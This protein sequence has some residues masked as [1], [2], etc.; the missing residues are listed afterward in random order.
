[1]SGK[2][3]F[4]RSQGIVPFGVGSI[5]NFPDDSLMMAGLDMWPTEI[6]D[7]TLGKQ[8]QFA[9]QIID[10]RLQRRLSFGREVKIDRFLS[11][12]EAP[13]MTQGYYG[14]SPLQLSTTGLMPFVRFPE[15][16]YCPACRTLH[17][18]PWN[19]KTGDERL[20]CNSK[21]SRKEGASKTC[22]DLPER[23]KHSLIPVRFAVACKSGH[24]MD[25]PWKE[26]VHKNNTSCGAG[27][28]ELFFYP[29]PTGGMDGLVIEC[30]RCKKRNTL[31]GIFGSNPFE[32]IWPT[33]PGERPWL[34]PKAK[35]NGC[36]CPP[37]SIQR[38]ASNI[39]FS[40][41]KS[42]ILIPPYSE[43][44]N[45]ILD[46]PD[47]WDLIQSLTKVNG[48]IADKAPLLSLAKKHGIESKLF[49]Q[50][51]HEKLDSVNEGE[52][53]ESE[54]QYRFT[55]YNAFLGPRPPFEE[56][57][58]FDILNIPIER[59]GSDF[60]KYISTVVLVKN[61]RE[62]RVLTGFTR[63]V[64]PESDEAGKAELSLR[65]KNW[66]P[67]MEVRG[68]GIFITLNLEEIV[69]WKRG[70]QNLK[71]KVDKINSR[72]KDVCDER[73]ISIRTINSELL[74]IHTLAHVLIRQ[75]SFDCGYEA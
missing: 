29:R 9:T 50:A 8:L 44:L 24:I 39:Y 31:R 28:G 58:D 67:A 20:K 38:G 1:M 18:V 73:N 10:G 11:P 52:Q 30:S 66:L 26:W 59:Y 17:K 72:L 22:H 61:L 43:T 15:W 54:E 51:V 57:R 2:L 68:E 49:I 42:S 69:N 40:M 71:D 27:S 21:F 37:R 56:R 75:L 41:L 48:R 47:E 35:E 64:P 13:S 55:E 19:T 32:K 70:N 60:S 23:R 34:G 25:F 7:N 5:V 62:T 53:E 16:H 6:S 33:C 63:L 12:A 45:Q 74:L 36:R 46:D 3:D 4:R 14:I 65:E